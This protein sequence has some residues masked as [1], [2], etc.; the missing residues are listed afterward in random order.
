EETLK[1]QADQSDNAN[2]E[3][4][5]KLEVALRELKKAKADTEAVRLFKNYTMDDANSRIN[6][7]FYQG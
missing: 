5:E 4:K 3:A 6:Q 7:Q 1:R 2:K